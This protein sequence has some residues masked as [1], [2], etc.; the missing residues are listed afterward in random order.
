MRVRRT[1]GRSEG[2]F[3]PRILPPR[4]WTCSSAPRGRDCL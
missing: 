2:L 4:V 3:L 1:G